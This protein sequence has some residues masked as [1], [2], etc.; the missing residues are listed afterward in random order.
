MLG[1]L[2]LEATQ[3]NGSHYRLSLGWSIH[4]NVASMVMFLTRLF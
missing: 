2:I 4:P 3:S 1:F